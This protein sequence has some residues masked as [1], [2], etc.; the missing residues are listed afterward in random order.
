MM[1]KPV[2]WALGAAATLLAACGG[3]EGRGGLTAEEE[4]MLDN[5]ARMTEDN[6]FDAS[7]DS[8][9]INESEL[10]EIEAEANV[11]IR[12]PAANAQ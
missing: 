9:V 1:R 5:A 4:R 3:E 8:L 12:G 6:V 2:W 7:P 11:A 10:R